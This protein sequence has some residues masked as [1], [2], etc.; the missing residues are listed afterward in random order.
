MN[1]LLV[2]MH[3][4]TGQ[5][6]LQQ[7]EEDVIA[8]IQTGAERMI[9]DE[10][11]AKTKQR[12]KEV[13]RDISLQE[14]KEKALALGS[15]TG[16][17]FEKALRGEEIGFICEVK[18]ASPSKGLIAAD[19]PY[20]KIAKEYEQAGATAISV[21]TE[22]YFFQGANDYLTQIRS[23]VS[24][25][26]LRKDFTIDPYMIY[27]AKVI[28]ADAILLICAVLTD[29]ELNA[30]YK[31][32]D[33]LGL[34][35]LV[36]AHDEEEVRRAIAI[37]ARIIGVNNRNLK[38]FTVDINNS[39]RLRQMIPEHVIFV[40]E[41]GMKDAADIQRLRENR[42]DA[43]LIG[44]TFMRSPDKKKMLGILRGVHAS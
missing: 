10:I 3:K 8:G 17:P 12:M 30:Y 15:D 31:L 16:Y 36:E 20:V 41:S 2:P 13:Q 7:M 42:T 27:E 43:V 38:D 37:G 26:I 33:S 35:V 11:V 1:L 34:S 18:K 29:E 22:P 19:F 6:D 5:T 9:L 40:S 44:E 4:I 25:P 14:I 21:L 23:Q 24:I 39:I 32:A 28:G